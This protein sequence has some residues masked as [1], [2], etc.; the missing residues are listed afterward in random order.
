[1]MLSSALRSGVLLSFLLSASADSFRRVLP[2]KAE[3]QSS[4]GSMGG[5]AEFSGDGDGMA[6][7][8]CRS[9]PLEPP[10][11]GVMP[12]KDRPH[13]I[14]A[15]DVDY[16]PYAQL[17]PASEDYPTSG[18]GPDFASG[19]MGVCDI[20]VTLVQTQWARCWES[21][22]IGQGLAL[23]EFHGCSAY[24]HASGVRNRYLEFSDPILDDSKAAGILTR[25]ENGVPVIDGN[26]NLDG[27]KI[28]T[29][30]GFAPTEDNLAIVTNQCTGEP[31]SGYEW[32]EPSF[33]TDYPNDDALRTVLNGDADA[34]WVYADQAFRSGCAENDNPPWDCELWDGLGDT[35]AYVQT[36]MFEWARAG[37]TLTIAKKGAGV[38][39]VV[40]PCIAAFLQTEEYYNLCE[41]Y[42]FVSECFVNDYFPDAVVED[43]VV[44][45]LPTSEQT[46]T[47]NFGY[48]PCPA[49]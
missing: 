6:G 40:N 14:L 20:D 18:F 36:G 30:V 41:K 15:Q 3:R 38:A 26:S 4:D 17:G 27:V 11:A 25:L 28:T 22:R 42:D 48:C 45:D 1:M 31:Y 16:P 35:F 34:M 2:A 23:G 12:G 47:C 5:P 29:V 8:T 39:D 9:A 46:S 7:P 13:V 44:F 33:T 24:T 37:T 10:L 21:D 43:T 32:V 19:M 49:R